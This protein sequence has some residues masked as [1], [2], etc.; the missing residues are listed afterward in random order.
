MIIKTR[1]QAAEDGDK[2]YRT[3]RTCKNGHDSPRYTS[4]GICCRCNVEAAR[5]YNKTMQQTYTAKLR[6]HF[7]YSLH[8]DDHAA[9]LAYCQAL[10]LARGRAPTSSFSE[11]VGPSAQY[12]ERAIALT[13]EAL[14]PPPQQPYLPA[15]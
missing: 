8:P 5:R 3:G 6:G 9:A 10:D 15:P 7:S 11:P 13:R 1:R 4:S 12:I 14:D 2:K